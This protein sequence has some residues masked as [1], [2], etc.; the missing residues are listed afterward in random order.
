MFKNSEGYADPTAG[1]AMSLIMKEYRQKQ[2][3]RYA[4]KNR[5]RIYVASKYAGNVEANVAAAIGYCRRV[6]DE[7]HMPIASHLLYCQILNDNDPEE[8]ELGLMFGLALLRLCD[9]V[10]VFGTVSPGVAQEI[11]EAKRLNKRLKYFEG[12]GV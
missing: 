7:G 4:D 8:R 11:E 10:W 5:R 3:K 2:K 6:I 9:E 12:V 1:A